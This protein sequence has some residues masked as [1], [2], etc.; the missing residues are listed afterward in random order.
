MHHNPGFQ[1][2][3]KF[4]MKNGVFQRPVSPKDGEPIRS[5]SIYF[6]AG[7]KSYGFRMSTKSFSVTP[8]LKQL[9]FRPDI[10]TVFKQ[11]ATSFKAMAMGVV[12][13]GMLSDGAEGLQ[14]MGLNRCA[15]WIQDPS[16][17]MFKDMPLAAKEKAPFAKIG[18]IKQIAE[19]INM[20]SRQSLKIEPIVNMLTRF[21]LQRPRS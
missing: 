18:T 3:S 5:G 17:A 21:S 13:T 19:R 2:M 15:T 4:E 1:F 11:A 10:D 12:M 16:T 20:I 14:A 9:K 7:D 8:L 6:L